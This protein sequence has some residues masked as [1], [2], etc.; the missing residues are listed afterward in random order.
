MVGRRGAGTTAAAC[1]RTIAGHRLDGWRWGSVRVGL[2]SPTERDQMLRCVRDPRGLRAESGVQRAVLTASGIDDVCRVE[3][4]DGAARCR[5]DLRIHIDA[6]RDATLPD[7]RDVESDTPLRPV[8]RIMI[9][10]LLRDEYL[11]T[12]VGDDAAFEDRVRLPKSVVLRRG[13]HA[14]ASAG[15]PRPEKGTEHGRAEGDGPSRSRD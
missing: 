14:D 13:R 2:T 3:V 12:L 10:G 9:E 1:S 7:A 5:G 8:D 6:L 11:H 15:N 4:Q